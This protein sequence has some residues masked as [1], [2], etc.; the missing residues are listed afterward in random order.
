MDGKRK[1]VPTKMRADSTVYLRLSFV[2]CL[3]GCNYVAS[4]YL[5][6]DFSPVLLSFLRLVVLSALLV[7]VTLFIK[8][9]GRPSRSEWLAL[10]GVGAFGTTLGQTLYFYGLEHS[11]AGKAAFILALTPVLTTFLARLFLA[12]PL[13]VR[14]VGGSALAVAGVGLIA[15]LGGD[16]SGFSIGD[17]LLLLAALM[18][19]VSL[20]FIRKLT[21]T[22]PSYDITILST[23]IGTLLMVPTLFWE[24]GQAQM[25]VS[26]SGLM[27]TVLVLTAVIGQGVTAFMWNRG[28][29]EVGASASA[30]FMNIPPFV[31]IVFAYFVLGDPIHLRQLAG[32]LLIVAGVIVSNANRQERPLEVKEE[33]GAPSV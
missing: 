32:G 13:T 19:S 33:R 7:L 4:A 25:H 6:T 5:L 20:L 9:M 16:E 28:I 12:E 26:G 24:S 27:W 21:S 15:A 30:T 1:E 22:L 10:L 23:L 31:A 8:R 2:S 3:I 18:F 29:A 14:K 17:P 11:S